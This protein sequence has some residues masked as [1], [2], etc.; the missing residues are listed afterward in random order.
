MTTMA[1]DSFLREFLAA[2]APGSPVSLAHPV[3]FPA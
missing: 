1:E 3:A 2:L